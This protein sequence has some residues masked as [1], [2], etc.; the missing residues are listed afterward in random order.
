MWR[1]FGPWFCG[2]VRIWPDGYFLPRLDVGF[3]SLLFLRRVAALV[4]LQAL[5]G[6]FC[7]ASSASTHA[8][9]LSV[10][11]PFG[12][13]VPFNQSVMRERDTPRS[14]ANRDFPPSSL[15]R[16][17]ARANSLARVIADT[18]ALCSFYRTE[19]RAEFSDRNPA[20]VR[21][22]GAHEILSLPG[23]GRRAAVGLRHGHERASQT[24]GGQARA[25]HARIDHARSN[26]AMVR[27][28]LRAIF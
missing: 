12:S 14:L 25:R 5:P 3:V 13:N 8:S 9:S 22:H 19:S 11:S 6:L 28:A 7:F 20:R 10:A 24:C 16:A 17:R 23:C 18:R 1:R 15:V 2:L 21:Y 4:V 26:V 27:A